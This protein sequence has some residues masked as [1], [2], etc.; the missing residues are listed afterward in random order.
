VAGALAA[1]AEQQPAGGRGQR[2]I[3]DTVGA[4]ADQDA[5]AP[6]VLPEGVE[7]PVHGLPERAGDPGLLGFFG[8][9]KLC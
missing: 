7:I 1:V 3:T 4:V 2:A 9:L 8:G 6:D 5:L